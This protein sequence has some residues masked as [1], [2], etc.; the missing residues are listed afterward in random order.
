M[1]NRR[2]YEKFGKHV[3]DN[4]DA[5]KSSEN[6]TLVDKDVREAYKEIFGDAL[7]EYNDKQKRADRKIDDYYDHIKK[8]KNGEKPFYEDVVQWGSK[9]DFEK[10]PELREKAKQALVEYA[11]SFGERN[12]NLKVIG[13]YIHMDEASPHL[14][15]DYVPIAHGYSRGLS[16]R[17]SLDKAMKEMGFIPENESRKNNATKLWKENERAAF[18]DICRSHGLE[19]D[20]ERTST[21]KSLSVEEYKDAKDRM[22]SELERQKLELESSANHLTVLVDDLNN[23]HDNVLN[24]IE[25]E[26]SKL[27]KVESDVKQQMIEF[28]LQSADIKNNINH[29]A[30][31]KDA[32]ESDI[33]DLRAD[34]DSLDEEINALKKEKEELREEKEIIEETIASLDVSGKK[35]KYGSQWDIAEARVRLS[36]EKDKRIALLE[37]VLDKLQEAFPQLSPIIQQMTLEAGRQSRNK[38]QEQV[39]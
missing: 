9:E 23:R 37:K 15:I 18:G 2:E 7:K 17:N 19:V 20:A 14:H 3:P 36:K 13:A 25:S 38:G 28:E 35:E 39:K 24:L 10:N 22:M 32:L 33:D 16:M 5:S 29:L 31:E 34:K 1:H 6:I 4:I 27:D 8:S 21:R 12:P 30:E 26:Y 11:K